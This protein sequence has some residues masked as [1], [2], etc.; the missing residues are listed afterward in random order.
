[1]KDT[2]D[3]F[4]TAMEGYRNLNPKFRELVRREATQELI[5]CGAH[6]VGSSDVNHSIYQM[7]RQHGSMDNVVQ[8]CLDNF[9]ANVMA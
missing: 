6:E 7:Y 4:K 1:M 3:N 2:I 8:H 9:F 5:D